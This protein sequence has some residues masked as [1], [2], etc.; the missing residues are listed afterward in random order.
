MTAAGQQDD[1][2][3]GAAAVVVN[4]SVVDSRVPTVVDLFLETNATRQLMRKT[5]SDFVKAAVYDDWEL[6]MLLVSCLSY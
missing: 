5:Y 2:A 4:E 3:A 1:E 6:L